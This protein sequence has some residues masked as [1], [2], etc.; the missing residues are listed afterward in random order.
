MKVVS[1][2]HQ[3]ILNEPEG[4]KANENPETTGGLLILLTFTLR[5]FSGLLPLK[6]L[7]E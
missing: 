7:T 1:W 3:R 6:E 2:M 4:R 5:L